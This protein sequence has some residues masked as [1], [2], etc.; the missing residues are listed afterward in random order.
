M[1]KKTMKKTYNITLNVTIDVKKSTNGRDIPWVKFKG[2]KNGVISKSNR[3]IE[4]EAVV[5]MTEDNMR[6]IGEQIFEAAKQM[7]YD[8][9]L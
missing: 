6:Y 7:Y 1:D 8:D 5:L 2:W 3:F 9:K 4:T